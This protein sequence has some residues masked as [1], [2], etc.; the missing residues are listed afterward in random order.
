ML[1][2]RSKKKKTFF[3]FFKVFPQGIKFFY[4][5]F[6]FETFSLDFYFFA[7]NVYSIKLFIKSADIYQSHFFFFFEKSHLGFIGKKKKICYTPEED[8][9]SLKIIF[10]DLEIVIHFYNVWSKIT[11]KI[12]FFFLLE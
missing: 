6:F 9:I 10:R 1:P 2:R 11:W 8:L 7:E 4:W 5:T 12:R 3:N